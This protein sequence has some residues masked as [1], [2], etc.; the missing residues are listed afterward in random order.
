MCLFVNN[1]RD[2]MFFDKNYIHKDSLVEDYV[3]GTKLYFY[4]LWSGLDS[5]ARVTLDG[6]FSVYYSR[7]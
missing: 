4:Y 1:L 3:I 6:N 5:L 7:I 2:G